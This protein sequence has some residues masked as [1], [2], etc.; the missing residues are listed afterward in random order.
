M[1]QIRNCVAQ[2]QGHV[3]PALA[4]ALASAALPHVSTAKAEVVL[5]S[6]CSQPN[7]TDGEIAGGDGLI[8]DGQGDLFGTA[9]GYGT[10]TEQGTTL[11]GA[12]IYELSSSGIETPIYNFCP[13]GNCPSN[14]Q[15]PIGPLIMDAA[16]DLYG[17]TQSAGG[18]AP[19]GTLYKLTQG[20]S[21]TVLHAFAGRKDGCQPAGS[22]VADRSG[23]L[24][25]T[26]AGDST[27]SATPYGTVFKA[28]S[29]RKLTTIYTFTGGNDG[30]DPDALLPD[31]DGNL[32]GLAAKG[33]AHG[34]GTVFK[35]AKDGT[36]TVLYAFMGG[37]DG[38]YPSGKLIADGAGNLYGTT[39]FGGD[40]S[41]GCGTAFKVAPSGMKSVLHVF[42]GGAAD[43]ANPDGLVSDSAGNFYGATEWGGGKSCTIGC[44]AVFKLTPGG[45]ETVLYAFKGG[46]GGA[47]P[48]GGL[49]LSKGYLYGVTIFGGNTATACADNPYPGCGVAFKLK[50]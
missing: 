8:S 39:A 28:S 5:Y 10:S 13:P 20:G 15:D 6:F 49:L 34:H 18:S 35:L 27:D 31:E 30:D 36:F 2:G 12:V 42:L 14:L 32:F 44:G 16:G 38:S 40:A 48:A 37:T 23:E 25:G 26:T 41:C 29:A 45:M 21:L 1:F 47:L 19:C 24:Y 17:V 11:T 46:K 33:G 9:G 4:L 43:G 50:S 22:L 3:I 7:C